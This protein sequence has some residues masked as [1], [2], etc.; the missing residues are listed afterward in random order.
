M[1]SADCVAHDRYDQDFWI[2][3]QQR[4]FRGWRNVRK[5]S[6]ISIELNAIDTREVLQEHLTKKRSP[7]DCAADSGYKLLFL[8]GLDKIIGCTLLHEI[9]SKIHVGISR[10]Y[11]DR[12]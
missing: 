5:L 11:Y 10:Q 9:H 1:T 4:R 3:D 7:A 12:S 2:P 6:G 8:H